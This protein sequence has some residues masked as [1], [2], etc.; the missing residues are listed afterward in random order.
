MKDFGDW[1]GAA[2]PLDFKDPGGPPPKPKPPRKPLFATDALSYSLAQAISALQDMG[3]KPHIASDTLQGHCLRC[4]GSVIISAQRALEAID[5]HYLNGR[6]ARLC[7]Y[8]QQTMSN[9][10]RYP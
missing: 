4:N 6:D 9:I 7:T 5:N 1:L 8:C 10:R 3:F 2:K